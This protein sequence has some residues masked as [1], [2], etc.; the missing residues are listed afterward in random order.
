MHAS[1]QHKWTRAIL[2]MWAQTPAIAALMAR[3]FETAPPALRG[4]TI[5]ML[6][7]AATS[8]DSMT[9]TPIVAVLTPRSPPAAPV[10]RH[11]DHVIFKNSADFE[12]P[13]V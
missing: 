4:A 13:S 12:A 1:P 6:S 11:M 10:A 8:P 9:S 2:H 5:L 3:E 7:G